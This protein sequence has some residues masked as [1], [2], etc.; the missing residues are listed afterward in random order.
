MT[1][2]SLASEFGDA[3]L[4]ITEHLG[5]DLANKCV[6]RNVYVAD[7]WDEDGKRIQKFTIDVHWNPL[8]PKNPLEG[9][10]L[11]SEEFV[12][13]ELETPGTKLEVFREKVD[14]IVAEFLARSE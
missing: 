6:I 14:S 2:K 10:K 1:V 13:E 7:D 5:V 12:R 4:F 8:F 3:D 9:M 11:E